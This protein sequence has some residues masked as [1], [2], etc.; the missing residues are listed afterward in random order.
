MSRTLSIVLN[1]FVHDSR[2]LRQLNTLSEQGHD[3]RLF[4]LHSEGLPQQEQTGGFCITRMKLWTRSWPGHMC[5][6]V[7]KYAE[8][9]LRM[10]VAGVRWRPALIHANDVHALPIA[11][12]IS[13]LTGAKLLYD[14]HEMWSDE[15]YFRYRGFPAWAFRV[16][17]P[18][19]RFLARRAHAVVTVSEGIAVH[20]AR[21]LDIAVPEVVR[22]VPVARVGVPDSGADALHTILGVSPATRIVLHLGGM[23][24][25]RGLETLIDAMPTVRGDAIAVLLGPCDHD[26]YMRGLQVR[27]ETLGLRERVRFLPPVSASE[28]CTYAHGATIGVALFESACLSHTFELPNKLFEYLQAGLPVVV[29][30]MPEMARLVDAYGVGLTV[31]EANSMQLA[32]AL[33]SL[34]DS[35]VEL[36]RFRQAAQS[37]AR[38]LNWERESVR[39]RDIYTRLCPC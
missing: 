10:V 17:L 2:V 20:M 30:D 27:I 18:A 21:V 9:L 13:R 26:E 24:P 19:E 28:V 14:S 1:S 33:N 22:N 15:T 37:A 34:L 32:D 35:P 5:V 4:A 38:E 3:T 7:L 11:F 12:V 6:R 23:E 39:L 8:C 25:S 36:Q 29:S 31:Q 16:S